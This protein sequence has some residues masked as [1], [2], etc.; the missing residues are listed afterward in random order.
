[1]KKAL[2]MV[3]LIALSFALTACG[4]SS[5]SDDCPPPMKTLRGCVSGA[6]I[7]GAKVFAKLDCLRE[8]YKKH[9]YK[10]KALLV[11]ETNDEG[12]IIFDEDAL[13]KLDR[14]KNVFLFSKGG[15][16]FNCAINCDGSG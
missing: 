2:F 6:P 9:E 15:K 13:A 3:A 7:A 1:M 5:G 12:C 16:Q 14:T 11:G 4:G 10:D 8:E